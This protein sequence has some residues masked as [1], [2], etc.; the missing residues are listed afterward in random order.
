VFVLLATWGA[1]PFFD[2][3]RAF[4]RDAR[5]VPIKFAGYAISYRAGHPHVRIEQRRYVTLKAYMGDIAVH[6]TREYLEEV[7]GQLPFEPYAPVRGQIECLFREVNRR[8]KLAQY[9]ALSRS[10][11]R[12]RRR[13]ANPFQDKSPGVTGEALG[14]IAA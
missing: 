11:L 14:P 4:I 5:K 2:E 12:L 8:R 3:E 7:F 1:H 10:C 9:E 13:I 6:R